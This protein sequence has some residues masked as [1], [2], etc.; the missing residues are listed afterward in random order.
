MTMASLA[1]AA[2]SAVGANEVLARVGAYFHDIGKIEKP[3]YFAE[4]Q[5]GTRNRH[6]KLAPRM[7]SLI[8]QNHVKKG[9]MLA[10]EH[11]LPEEI[12]ARL[13]TDG[14][15][16]HDHYIYGTPKRPERP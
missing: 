6:D 13:P 5:R 12:V 14:A 11:N 16:Q 9:M 8:I 7:S 4:N 1:E 10:R 3:T 2:A 15:S